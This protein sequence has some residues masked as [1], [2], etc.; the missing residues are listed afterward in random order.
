MSRV[1]L[2]DNTHSARQSVASHGFESGVFYS[3]TAHY[4]NLNLGSQLR[5]AQ[6]VSAPSQ[7]TETVRDIR[8]LSAGSFERLAAVGRPFEYAHFSCLDQAIPTL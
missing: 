6:F 4:L 8:A 2:A 3:P 7:I 1:G 5:H